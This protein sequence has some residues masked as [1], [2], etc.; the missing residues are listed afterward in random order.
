MSLCWIQLH[1]PFE[2]V[3]GTTLYQGT[4]SGKVM[5]ASRICEHADGQIQDGSLCDCSQG[6]S[7]APTFHHSSLSCLHS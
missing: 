4:V 1:T 7:R 3:L 5:A 2:H 6:L